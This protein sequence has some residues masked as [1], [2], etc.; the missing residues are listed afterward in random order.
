M[1]DVLQGML[2]IANFAEQYT[3]SVVNSEVFVEI[4]TYQS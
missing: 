1:A 2:D 3:N 4:T